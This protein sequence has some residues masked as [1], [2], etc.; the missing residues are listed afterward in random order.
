[1]QF[2]LVKAAKTGENVKLSYTAGNMESIDGYKL[3]SFS[4]YPVTNIVPVLALVSAGTSADGKSILAYYNKPM[5]D[6]SAQLSSFRIYVNNTSVS[7]DSVRLKSGNDSIMVIT[8]KNSVKTGDALL[9]F[10]Y[11][12]TVTSS[13]GESL[14]LIRFFNVAN[15]VV[16]TGISEQIRSGVNLYPNPTKDFIYIEGITGV[17]NVKIYNPMGQLVFE[18]V[19]DTDDSKINVSELP[20]GTYLISV[21]SDNTL[22][23]K[24]Q[25]IKVK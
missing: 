19:L 8:L 25:F 23:L 3:A 18:K 10:Y 12:G 24:T 11:P 15:N 9:F 4:N 2:S 22:V 13:D 20:N 17:S 1:M 16:V 21:F 7:L 14:A 6:P 5:T